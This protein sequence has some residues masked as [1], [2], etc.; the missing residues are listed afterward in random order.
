MD[1][2]HSV[3]MHEEEELSVSGVS[4]LVSP[5]VGEDAVTGLSDSVALLFGHFLSV[6][7]LK[8]SPACVD[9]STNK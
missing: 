4:N 6:N 5:D 2:A 3:C 7:I 8:L 9:A 1:S